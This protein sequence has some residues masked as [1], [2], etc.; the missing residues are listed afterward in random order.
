MASN[1][2]TDKGK[3]RLIKAVVR[4][5]KNVQTMTD[6]AY[7]F[8][9]QSNG[10]IAHYGIYHFRKYY[11]DN[12]L[13]AD[14]LAFKDMNQY[15]NFCKGKKNYDYYMQRKEIYNEICRRLM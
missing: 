8:L 11:E 3:E 15:D 6:E 13:K 1:L 14:I 9:Y 5:A 12:S 4:A 7:D 2:L 10:F